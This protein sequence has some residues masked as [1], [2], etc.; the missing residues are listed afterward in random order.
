MDNLDIVGYYFVIFLRSKRDVAEEDVVAELQE[1]FL[2]SSTRE[3]A[4]LLLDAQD[5]V[6]GRLET[7]GD[8]V[9]YS[10]MLF[11]AMPDPEQIQDFATFL[12]CKLNYPSL[13]HPADLF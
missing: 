8:W 2:S 1:K 10:A 11:D 4:G 7:R 12:F 9:T 3:T 13:D 6:P 5:W